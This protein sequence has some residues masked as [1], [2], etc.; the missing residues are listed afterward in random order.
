MQEPVYHSRD[1]KLISNGSKETCPRKGVCERFSLRGRNGSA[2]MSSKVLRP[3]NC[4][5]RTYLDRYNCGN[6]RWPRGLP[7]PTVLAPVLESRQSVLLPFG[8]FIQILLAP[9]LE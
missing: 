4:R 3:L 1:R 6:P 7:T 5:P 2:R 9:V 8:D